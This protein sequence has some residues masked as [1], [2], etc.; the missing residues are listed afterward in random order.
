MKN[1]NLI[2]SGDAVR[3]ALFAVIV[4]LFLSGC[5]MPDPENIVGYHLVNSKNKQLSNKLLSADV[6]MATQKRIKISS[7]C[8][9][10]YKNGA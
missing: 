6:C 2:K 8:V 5:D 7:R 10:V 1:L 4:C 3:C 9:P